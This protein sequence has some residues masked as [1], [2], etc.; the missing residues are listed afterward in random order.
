MGEGLLSPGV[1]PRSVVPAPDL[2]LGGEES[3]HP[4]GAPG[5]NTT[6]RDSN[7]GPQAK[8]E[9]VSE[10][11]AGV[12]EDTGGVYSSQEGVCV[13]LVL[14]DDDVSVAGAV[15]VD[16]INR[17]LHVGHDLHSATEA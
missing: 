17:L 4:H 13:L 12:V 16:V 2:P 10:P 7:L 11:G 8:P 9:P 5:V 15:P 3:L 14:S 6:S 1:L